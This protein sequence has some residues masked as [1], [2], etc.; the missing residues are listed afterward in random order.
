MKK[1]INIILTLGLIAFTASCVKEYGP[2]EPG[3]PDNANCYGVYFPVQEGTGAHTFDPTQPTEA[4][5]IVARQHANGAITVPVEIVDEN[6]VFNVEPITFADGQSE[7]VLHITFPNAGIG[8]EYP[9]SVTIT[10]PDYASKYNSGATSF[11]FSVFRVEWKTLSN[12]TTGEPAE[13]TFY[14]EWWDEVHVTR[15]KYYEV[16][17]IRTCIA[18][19]DNPDEGV[20]GMKTDFTF[21]WNTKTNKVDIP[22]NF[23]GWDYDDQGKP[24]PESDCSSPVYVFDWYSYFVMRGQYSKDVDSFYAANGANYPRS[25]YDPQT[26]IFYLN[27]QFYIIGLGGW[28]GLEYDTEAWV[29]GFVRT[30]YSLEVET[31]YSTEPGKAPV[32]F[33]TGVDT[34]EI[35]YIVVDGEITATQAEKYMASIADGTAEGVAS[36]TEFEYNEEDNVNEAALELSFDE[37]GFYSVVA[38]SF[39]E[40]DGAQEGAFASLFVAGPDDPS[41][42]VKV[43]AVLEEVPSRFGYDKKSALGF[44]IAGKELTEVKYSIFASADVEKAGIDA[45][46][47]ELRSGKAVS[48]SVLGAI[49]ATGGY[50]SAVKGLNALTK[51]TLVVW[52]TNGSKAKVVTSE[53][54]TEGL[55]NEV[56]ASGA[57]TGGALLFGEDFVTST[58]VEYNPNTEHF[59]I[60]N[61]LD[62]DAP[63]VFDLNS[64]DNTIDVLPSYSGIDYA[65]GAPINVYEAS[66]VYSNLT[67][68]GLPADAH[69]YF[70][71]E[72]GKYFFCLAYYVP[73]AGG[74][75][76][77][78]Y[79]TFEVGE[80]AEE[81]A[82]NA[83]S[84]ISTVSTVGCKPGVAS[85]IRK[86]GVASYSYERTPKAASFTSKAISPRAKRSVKAAAKNFGKPVASND[87]LF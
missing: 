3:E 4:D 67:K 36:V 40:A 13:V 7:T 56:I 27:C 24:K 81:V 50:A 62:F 54:M 73:A 25:Y 41:Y 82:E 43:D 77:A 46:V 30:D 23:M 28:T 47:E 45:V 60:P 72:T 6:G 78:A 14:E 66:D 57:F 34:K 52:A 79:E 70:D 74:G 61:F 71:E 20:W 1:F 17:G 48:E 32:Y 33:T 11:D 39:D 51:Y 10:D 15:I 49:N 63:L 44:Y 37:T 84:V 87:I 59:E 85:L 42:D 58:T 5:I 19:T 68:Y 65:A 53:Y 18:Y 55:P 12:P 16:D 31:D 2:H 26:G 75:F 9:L 21:T 83:E 22:Q 86:P 29:S 64:D 69:S 80:S 76:G 38:V 35:K 8:V